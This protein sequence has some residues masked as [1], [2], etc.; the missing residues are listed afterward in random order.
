M[1]NLRKL[2]SEKGL[3]QDK[4]AKLVG[5]SQQSIH[6]YESGTFEPDIFMLKKF[7]DL[8]ET[9]IDY[10]L[11]YTDIRHKIEHVEAYELNSGEAELIDKFRKLSGR[12]RDCV[13]NVIDTFIETGKN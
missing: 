2:R 1:K 8:F 13:I 4:L 7:A 10:L 11:G 12:A 6:N 9:S 3:S 5:T